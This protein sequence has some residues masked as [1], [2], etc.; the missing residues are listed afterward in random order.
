MIIVRRDGM[1]QM[2]NHRI[3]KKYSQEEIDDLIYESGL[4]RIKLKKK[5]KENDK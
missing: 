1:K 3:K 2:N 5:Q 4:R